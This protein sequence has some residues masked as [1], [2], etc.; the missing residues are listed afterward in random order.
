MPTIVTLWS[1]VVAFS[2]SGLVG[3]VFGIYPAL[4]AANMDPVEAL[5]HE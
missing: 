4:R 1:P 2:I 5:R 3:V